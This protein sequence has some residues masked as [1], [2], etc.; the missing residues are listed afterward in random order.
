VGIVTGAAGARAY[1]VAM[2]G[3]GMARVTI[4]AEPAVAGAGVVGLGA[5]NR[6]DSAL[7][8]R[9]APHV[10]GPGLSRP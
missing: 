8:D 7:C 1:D 2:V 4:A 5:G 10:D 3:A 9:C 6:L